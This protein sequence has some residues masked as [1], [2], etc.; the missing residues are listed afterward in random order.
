[1]ALDHLAA[2]RPGPIWLGVWSGKLKARAAYVARGF[3]KV[4]NIVFRSASW[5]DDELIFRRD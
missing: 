2:S 4:A 1:M 3:V 5:H